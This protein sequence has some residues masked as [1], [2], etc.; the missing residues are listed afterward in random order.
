MER[1]PLPFV[2]SWSRPGWRA[3]V[4]AVSLIAAV[5]LAPLLSCSGSGSELTDGSGQG[6][7]LNGLVSLSIEPTDVTLEIN[8]GETAEQQFTVEGSFADGSSRDVT[9]EVVWSTTLGGAS[10]VSGKLSTEL[11]GAGTVTAAAAGSSAV[12]TVTIK[13]SGQVELPSAPD[14]VGDKLDGAPEPSAAPTVAYPLD[15]SLFPSNL[16]D[17][18][19]QLT[20]GDA[21][22]SIA[23]IDI[24]GELID[25]KVVGACES[26][27]ADGCGVALVQWLVPMLAGASSKDLSIRVRLAAADG[28]AL[29]ESAPLE[30]LWTFTKVGGGLYYWTARHNGDTAIYRYDLDEQGTPP[31]AFFTEAS[32]PPLHD[33]TKTPCVGCHAVSLDGTKIG[34][35]FGGSDASDFTLLDVANG[36]P[37]AV[38]NT[39]P[40]GFA[41]F[42]ALSPDSKHLVTAFRGKLMLRNADNTLAA[43]GPITSDKTTGESLTH[44]FWAPDGSL[45]AYVGWVPGQNGASDSLNGDIAR[46]AQIFVTESDGS[47][48]SGETRLVVPRLDGRSS[49]YPA[50]SDDGQWLVFNRSRCDGPGTNKGYGEDPCDCYDDPSARVMVVPISGG[51]AVDLTAANGSGTTTNSW[52]RW[53]PSHG[54][55]RGENIYFVAFSSKR[56]YG[57]R[58]A[59][60]TDGSTP[61]QLWFAAVALTAG[62][63]LGASDP[64]FAPVWLPLQD[65][66]MENPTGNHVPQWAAKALPIPN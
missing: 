24:S 35:T 39:D 22:Q 44:P 54:S 43:L 23:R 46:G 28:S 4:F 42:S 34:L 32:S 55:F 36:A 12:A 60:S 13:V 66:D 1:K 21:S 37:Y 3:V 14:D 29:G 18:E 11:A 52:P 51:D 26:I 47:S 20:K 58:L 31:E 8:Y 59:G 6:G 63:P 62:K 10:V 19:F 25:L 38:E 33:G 53:S 64:S 16:G 50:I 2:S 48:I 56:A 15:G 65:E 27:G 9:A 40:N 30:V 5:T 61:P 57:L 17:V 41:T 7:V 49:Y 45:L